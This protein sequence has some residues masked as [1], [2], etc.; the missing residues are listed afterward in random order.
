MIFIKKYVI[1]YIENK[2]GKNEMWF[3]LGFNIVGLAVILYL[4]SL[5]YPMAAFIVPALN[6]L[7]DMYLDIPEFVKRII[8][9]L[10][11][12]LFLPALI[13]YAIIVF[14]LVLVVVINLT[15]IKRR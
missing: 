5:D 4:S 14:V 1:I 10:F 11:I 8:D 13:V 12:I 2:K 15:L 9:I 7:I 3:W 6:E